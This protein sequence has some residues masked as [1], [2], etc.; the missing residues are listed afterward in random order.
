M[1][2][3]GRDCRLGNYWLYVSRPPPMPP[4]VVSEAALPDNYCGKAEASAAVFVAES[5]IDTY[6]LMPLPMAK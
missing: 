3:F 5:G 1:G 4:E 2:L 6:G